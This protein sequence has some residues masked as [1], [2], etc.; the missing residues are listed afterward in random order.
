MKNILCFGDSNTFGYIPAS[1]KRYDENTR[2]TGILAQKLGNDY[3][4]I[5]AGCN[6]RNG[7]IDSLDGELFTGYKV[8]PRY[9]MNPADIVILWIG[10][11]DIQKFYNP[12]LDTL[13]QGLDIMLKQIKSVGSKIIVVSPPIINNNILNGHFAY[14]FDETSVAKS[15]LL[16]DLYKEVSK[17]NNVGFIDINQYVSVSELDG[18]HYSQES[19]SVIA[20]T[21]YDCVKQL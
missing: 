11:N 13:K 21:L 18:L 3:K 16:P 5:E 7:F 6:N 14:Q 17:Q 1:G 2:W 9:L 4:I 12:N 20:N 19:H 8:L 10:A 15:K